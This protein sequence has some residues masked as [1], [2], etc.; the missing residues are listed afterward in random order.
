MLWA[1]AMTIR[2]APILLA[3]SIASAACGDDDDQ[4]DA[5]VGEADAALPDAGGEIDA[6]EA[7]AAL[8]DA[9]G[10]YATQVFQHSCGPT[11]GP[12]ITLVLSSE[13][14]AK[15]CTPNFFDPTVVFTVYL[16][17]FVIEAPADFVFSNDIL[18][19][20]G[21]VCPGGKVD[22]DAA[23]AG[24]IHFETFDNGAGATGTWELTT[25]R[26]VESGSFAATSC[27]P[28]G[29]DPICG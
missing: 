28:E 17:D 22:C 11:D 24:E 3:F 26:G 13:V 2:L 14:D 27:V 15:T 5:A 7:D 10:T 29:G 19:G 20:D 8:P 9:G 21:R 1:E 6:G 25:E 18:G 16:D 23:S 4:P 12:A